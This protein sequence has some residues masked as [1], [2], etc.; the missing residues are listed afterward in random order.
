MQWESLDKFSF[1]ITEVSSVLFS[2]GD[3]AYKFRAW[4][5]VVWGEWEHK[6]EWDLL[7]LLLPDHAK[8]ATVKHAYS[9]GAT[10][11]RCFLG[12]LIG[13]PSIAL[14]LVALLKWTYSLHGV[15]CTCFSAAL[16]GMALWP[17]TCT[18]RSNWLTLLMRCHTLHFV[19]NIPC[20]SSGGGRTWDCIKLGK[21]LH[22]WKTV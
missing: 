4:S 22:N 8:S 9:M 11:I 12:G 18:H 1:Y 13:A 14:R 2:P 7:S 16:P 5:W 15:I 3:T 21:K 19:I 10:W 17:C 20:L 6:E